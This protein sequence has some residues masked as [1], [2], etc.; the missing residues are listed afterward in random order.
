MGEHCS[1]GGFPFHDKTYADMHGKS[2]AF[3]ST[4]VRNRVHSGATMAP[5]TIWLHR[6]A[7]PKPPFGAAC[8]GCGVCCSAA[9]CPL[10]MLLGLRLRGRCRLLRFDAAR[11]R[12][13]CGLMPRADAPPASWRRRVLP[14]VTRWIGAG[15]GCDSTVQAAAAQG[16]RQ[17]AR[18]PHWG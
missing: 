18:R 10:G 6:D 16:R 15:V 14:L 5:L 7:P 3:G 12:Y 11:S 9:P 2:G 13:R 8:N 4:R 1:T 17:S